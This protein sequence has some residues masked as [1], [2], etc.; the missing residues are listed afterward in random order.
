M[1]DRLGEIEPLFGFIISAVAI[2]LSGVMAPGPITA[3]TLAEGSRARHAGAVIGLGHVIVELPLI[4]LLVAGMGAI[5]ESPGVQLGIGLAGG[6]VLVLMGLQLLF[7][8]PTPHI[9][10]QVPVHRHPLLTGMV[11][12]AANPY[13]LVWWATVG[14]ALTSRSLQYGLVALVLFVLAH[15]A[16]DIGWLAVLTWA[17]FKGTEVFGRRAQTVVSAVCG[18]VLLGFG[19][20]FLYDAGFGLGFV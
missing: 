20:K 4:L 9:D 18:T 16:C 13:F 6:A 8:A 17:G 12:T 3:A 19:L 15:W 14:L 5:F 11:L 10:P 1:R 2:S 7:A